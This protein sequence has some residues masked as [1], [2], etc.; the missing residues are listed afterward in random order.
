[1]AGPVLPHQPEHPAGPTAGAA[2][3]AGSAKGLNS[4]PL[5][6]RTVLAGA[7]SAAAS[8]LLVGA[9]PPGAPPGAPR[10][11]DALDLS[12][13]E[14]RAGRHWLTLRLD[15]AGKGAPVRL[16]LT[17]SSRE[18]TEFKVSSTTGHTT[19]G[20]GPDAAE[21]GSGATVRALPG[22]PGEVWV[23]PRKLGSPLVPADRLLVESAQ[24]KVAVDVYIEPS[25]GHWFPAGHNLS[26]L[27]L[28][29]VAVHA[30]LV[31]KGD[32]AEVIM[33]SPARKTSGGKPMRDPDRPGQ[34]L[35]ETFEMGA[36]EARAL[37]VATLRTR[38]RLMQEGGGAAS[39]NIFCSGQAGLPDGRL[40]V[41]GGHVHPNEKHDDSAAVHV[42]SPDAAAGWKKAA[43]LGVYR[44]YPTVTALPDGRMLISGGSRTVPTQDPVR[45]NGPDGYWNVINNDYQIFADGRLITPPGNR[46]IDPRMFS[47][48]RNRLATYPNV[49][50]V[51]GKDRAKPGVVL[52]ESNRAWMLTYD[53]TQATPL[54]LADKL[55]PM[56]TKGSRSYPQ[57]GSHV[58]LPL[59][60][61]S[62]KI[63]IL[64]AGGQHEDTEDHRSLDEGQKSTATAEIFDYDP[65]RLP[66][67]QTGWRKTADL[68]QA[69]V[70][71]DATLL[72]DGKVLI[73]GGSQLGWGDLNSQPVY[74]AELFDPDTETF[75][76]AAKAATD[77]R[78]HSTALLQ[79]D[80]SVLKAGSTGGFGRHPRTNES[81]MEVH[82]TA[83]RYYPPYLW[84]G[85][86]PELTRVQG[87]ETGWVTLTYGT[88]FSATATGDSLDADSRMAVIRMGATTHG[89]NMDQRYVWLQTTSQRYNASD[90]EWSITANLPEDPALAPPGNYMLVLVD[91]TGVP[92][93]S[94]FV[95]VKS[96]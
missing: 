82:T 60:A 84:R 96:A 36:L 50:V 34:W 38:S 6:R 75:Q 22:Q 5:Q 2:G 29:I 93:P 31:R 81:M 23:T 76:L 7:L 20:V 15:G 37:D 13:A 3:T 17:S 80:G 16:P 88:G 21:Q 12:S 58:M 26:T 40:L 9:A 74:A 55:Y 79:P 44:W 94:R 70:L 72:A 51:P 89:N 11:P 35:W 61:G 45:D 57:Y 78:Y 14:V 52:V 42:Y 56:H 63:R 28:Q 19:V 77:R 69:R 65:R 25:Q 10:K 59:R 47:A 83:E 41:A 53:A 43:D 8:A 68:R 33:Y 95:Q 30:A 24:G 48:T 91:S 49:F 39:K 64:V 71:C 66:N 32:G 62:S 27:D 90:D 67:R 1:M 4:R 86:R 46:L 85:P 87:D 92:S 54:T 18:N 73:S